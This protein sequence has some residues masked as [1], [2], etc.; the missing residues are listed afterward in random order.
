MKNIV[1]HIAVS[2]N[3]TYILEQILLRYAEISHKLV[4]INGV[5]YKLFKKINFRNCERYE[6]LKN[7]KFVGEVE[8]IKNTKFQQNKITSQIC[9]LFVDHKYKNNGCGSYLFD[10]LINELKKGKNNVMYVANSEPNSEYNSES[11]SEKKFL[12]KRGFINPNNKSFWEMTMYYLF[13]E[14]NEHIYKK[15]NYYYKKT[16]L[17]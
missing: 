7:D 2:I 1:F 6:L 12:E 17:I 15:N 5:N 16:K 13:N 10:N 11:N 8:I 3:I 9:S 14:D 4:N